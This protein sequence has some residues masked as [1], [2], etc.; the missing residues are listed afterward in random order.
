MA[1]IPGQNTVTSLPGQMSTAIDRF[2]A[3]SNIP[4]TPKIP[5][6]GIMSTL[7]KYA[8]PIGLGLDIIGLATSIYDRITATDEA[9]NADARARSDYNA[10]LAREAAARAEEMN[11]YRTELN[12]SKRQIATQEKDKRLARQD[13]NRLEAMQI[14]QGKI[15]KWMTMVND[16]S[17]K[18]QYRQLM[19]GGR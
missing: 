15:D 3:G 11:R 2:T 19:K 12:M 8:G 4:S 7:T 18:D 13:K 17:Q 5:G 14:G 1:F 16:P 10:S 9:K 6:G